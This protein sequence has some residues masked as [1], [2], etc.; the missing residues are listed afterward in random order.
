MRLATG[1]RAGRGKG[2]ESYLIALGNARKTSTILREADATYLEEKLGSR[3]NW[4]TS[5][6]ARW[7]HLLEFLQAYGMTELSPVGTFLPW[8]DHIG[9]GRSK[10]RHRSGGRAAPLVE[11]RIVDIFGKPEP[12]RTV[13]EIVV[14]GDVVM[15]G[16]WERPE[17]TK[18]RSSTAGCIPATAATWTRTD[19]SISS[20]ASRT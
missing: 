6:V 13:G 12:P 17:E 4:Q 1:T 5:A 7:P 11:V 8:S 3:S 18:R 10:G 20:I 15:M 14:R 16:Y 2:S 9:E 19:S